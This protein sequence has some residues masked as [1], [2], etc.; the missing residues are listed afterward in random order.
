MRPITAARQDPKRPWIDDKN[1]S[2]NQEQRWQDDLLS[3]R[4]Y[5]GHRGIHGISQL[6]TTISDGSQPPR[7]LEY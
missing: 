4:E 7:A 2:S 3:V 6:T 5:D 1:Q